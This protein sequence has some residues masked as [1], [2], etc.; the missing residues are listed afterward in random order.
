MSILQQN[1]GVS[2]KLEALAEKIEA[3]CAESFARIEKI[4]QENQLW[5]LDCFRKEEIAPAH[6]A[7]DE[8][9]LKSLFSE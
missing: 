4:Q 8:S 6:F 9:L 5:V 1:Y 2:P 3:Q 7:A